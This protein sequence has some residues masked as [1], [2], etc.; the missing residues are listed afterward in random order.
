[1]TIFKWLNVI[2]ESFF[3]MFPLLSTWGRTHSCKCWIYRVRLFSAQAMMQAFYN[4]QDQC[5]PFLDYNWHRYIPISW[6]LYTDL[7]LYRADYQDH[8]KSCFDHYSPINNTHCMSFPESKIAISICSLTLTLDPKLGKTWQ[9]VGRG[10]SRDPVALIR[11][12]LYTK[13]HGHHALQGS[14]QRRFGDR[15]ERRVSWSVFE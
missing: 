8:D 9:Y 11:A 13:H 5:I 12:Y 14:E 1:M 3:W 6:S 7:I 15:E 2:Q 4:H 10:P